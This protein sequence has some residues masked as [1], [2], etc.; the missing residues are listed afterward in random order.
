MHV[1][2]PHT[3]RAAVH[4]EWLLLQLREDGALYRAARAPGRSLLAAPLE[5][6]L[7]G[8][9]E[10]TVLFPPTP[11]TSLAGLPGRATTW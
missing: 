8:A 6:W 2:V 7:A 11:S 1:D 4:R 10:L 5:A 3:A 9:R